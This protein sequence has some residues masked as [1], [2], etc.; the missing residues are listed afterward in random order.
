MRAEQNKASEEIV[1]IKDAIAKESLLNKM[2]TLKEQLVGSEEMLKKSCC[3]VATPD[4]ARTK[5][6]RHDCTRR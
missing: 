5:H 2:K 4:V 1:N 6:P 3:T